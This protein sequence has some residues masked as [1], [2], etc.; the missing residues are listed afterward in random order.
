VADRRVQITGLTLLSY[1]RQLR[2]Q[3]GSGRA[4]Y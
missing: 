2:L 3:K 1:F 4:G